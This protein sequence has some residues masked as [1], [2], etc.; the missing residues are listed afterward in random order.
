MPLHQEATDAINERGGAKHGLPQLL[1]DKAPDLRANILQVTPFSIAE[2]L[3]GKIIDEISAGLFTYRT[4]SCVVR[5][6]VPGFPGDWNGCVDLVPTKLGVEPHAV[7]KTVE[8]LREELENPKYRAFLEKEGTSFDIDKLSV[9]VAPE[10]DGD[11]VTL[12]EHPNR[13]GVSMVDMDRATG[14]PFIDFE[15]DSIL[16][17]GTIDERDELVARESL[18]IMRAV[19]ETGLFPDEGALQIELVVQ[20]L[21]EKLVAFLTQVKYFADR[22]YADFSLEGES[23]YTARNFGITNQEGTQLPVKATKYRRRN[24]VIDQEMDGREY[25]FVSGDNYG[26][27]T[28]EELPMSMTAYLPLI[29]PPRIDHKATRYIQRAL[30]H[31]NGCTFMDSPW[32]PY[33]GT[34]IMRASEV[35]IVSDG[36]RHEIEII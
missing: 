35:R 33:P 21:R 7:R 9:S 13:D 16:Y 23:P 6:G 12:S 10:I 8:E 28:P 24:P 19:R 14:C 17:C 3:N 31:E 2:G 20:P 15:G 29:A 26:D 27:L 34:E 22:R 18:R 11:K 4:N 25:M 32:T 36:V 1:H 30:M 5:V